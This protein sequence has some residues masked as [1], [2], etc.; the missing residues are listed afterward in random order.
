MADG[1]NYDLQYVPGRGWNA[2]GGQISA[3]S[4]WPYT[5]PPGPATIYGM[6]D[7]GAGV[8]QDPEDE[9]AYVGDRLYFEVNGIGIVVY[10]QVVA[11]EAGEGSS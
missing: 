1:G 2:E 5:Y 6:F 9:Q 8:G 10:L 11:I 4:S 3:I 7:A